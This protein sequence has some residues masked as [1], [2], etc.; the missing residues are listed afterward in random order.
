MCER[1]YAHV[2]PDTHVRINWNNLWNTVFIIAII[3]IAKNKKAQEMDEFK[4]CKHNSVAV[5]F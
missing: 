2:R 5:F 3:I 1:V 4:Y